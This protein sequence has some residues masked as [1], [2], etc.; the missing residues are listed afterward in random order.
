MASNHTANEKFLYLFDFLTESRN[1]PHRGALRFRNAVYGSCPS[2]LLIPLSCPLIALIRFVNERA[3]LFEYHPNPTR[4][5]R[6][7][8]LVTCGSQYR[9]TSYH[10]A[11]L[12]MLADPPARV[13]P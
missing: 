3:R 1:S 8:Y 12:H 7:N 6:L 4:L 11:F 5:A 13:E 10:T 2:F 9:A